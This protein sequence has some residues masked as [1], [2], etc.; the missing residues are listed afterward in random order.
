MKKTETESLMRRRKPKVRLQ[1]DRNVPER[2]KKTCC[3]ALRIRIAFEM[4]D[5]DLYG[6]WYVDS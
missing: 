4:C 6:I 3:S 2:L 1:I 5:V